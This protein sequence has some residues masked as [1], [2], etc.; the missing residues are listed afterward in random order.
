MAFVES[1][2][3]RGLR[4]KLGDKIYRKYKKRTVV[5]KLPDYSKVVRSSLQKE[6]SSRFREAV[7]FA[8]QMMADPSQYD[9]LK[10][11]A[12]GQS[13]YHYLISNFLKNS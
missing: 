3:F 9:E 12:R 2:L 4:G 8:K 7:A 13:V 1:L 10:K 6:G 5:T 11:R